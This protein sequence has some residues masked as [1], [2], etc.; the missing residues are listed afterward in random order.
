MKSGSVLYILML[1]FGKLASGNTR[2][3][4]AFVLRQKA[5]NL[6][7]CTE[8][9]KTTFYQRSEL[10]FFLICPLWNTNTGGPEQE[11]L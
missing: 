1:Q 3:L 6:L 10:R 2:R 7:A 4:L 8:N 5:N 9:K 11:S